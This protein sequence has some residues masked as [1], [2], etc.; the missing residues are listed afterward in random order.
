MIKTG[1]MIKR[2]R[3]INQRLEARE[4]NQRLQAARQQAIIRYCYRKR[5]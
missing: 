4:I 3:Q 1:D 2:N 5:G